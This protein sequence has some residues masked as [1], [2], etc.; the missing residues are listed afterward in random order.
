MLF[1]KIEEKQQYIWTCHVEN[2]SGFILINMGFHK[3]KLRHAKHA[4]EFRNSIISF[5][6]TRI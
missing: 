3:F 1:L 6:I 2:S 5:K 4:L